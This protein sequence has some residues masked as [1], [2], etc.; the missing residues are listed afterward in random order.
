MVYPEREVERQK[1]I[2]FAGDNPGIS[3]FSGTNNRIASSETKNANVVV[4]VL[5]TQPSNPLFLQ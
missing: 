3:F 2:V 1:N 4:C 5:K